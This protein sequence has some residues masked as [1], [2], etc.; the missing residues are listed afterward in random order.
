MAQTGVFPVYENQFK[1]G[2]EK[3]SAT[4]IADMETF[5]VSFSNGVETWTPM[6]HK[7]WQRALMT[8]KAVTITING[9]RNKGD[10][11]NDFIAKKAFTNGRDSEGYFC[12]TFPDGTTVEWDMAVFD[13]KNMG[14]GD[15]TNVAPL[16]FDVISNGKPTV[17]P[18]V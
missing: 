4:T 8:A 1:I 15:S 16:E 11:G 2:A 7:G 6:E 18:S 9:K 3:A 17:T 5:S 14:A 10:T 12:W 13:V